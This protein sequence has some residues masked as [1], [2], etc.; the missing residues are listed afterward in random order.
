MSEI[1]KRNQPG[2][3]IGQPGQ[4]QQQG[5]QPPGQ[6]PSMS[7]VPGLPPTGL[8][9][10]S[11]SLNQQYQQ[12]RMALQSQ[13]LGPAGGQ[14]GQKGQFGQTSLSQMAQQLAQSYGLDVSRGSM[15]DAQG[16]FQFTPD[17]LANDKLSQGDVAARMNYIAQ[18]INDRKIEQQQGKATAALQ[19]GL[20]QVQSRGRGSLAAMQ[21]GF[22]QSMAQVYTD[23]NL[24]PEQADFSYWIQKDKMDKAASIR[25]SEDDGGSSGDSV[26][27]RF[28]RWWSKRRDDQNLAERKEQHLRA[29]NKSKNTQQRIHRGRTNRARRHSFAFP[30]GYASS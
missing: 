18:A 20:G 4:Q 25:K 29:E 19:T 10:Q 13:T 22:Y 9:Q 23:P 6:S 14:A 26:K 12:G 21:S 2:Q 11:T 17:Q 27:D 3:S 16:N 7:Q 15:V 30:G 8:Q 5:Q 1:V 24:L 28:D